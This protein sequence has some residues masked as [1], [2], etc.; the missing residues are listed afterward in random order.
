MILLIIRGHNLKE[1]ILGIKVCP[2]EFIGTQVTGEAGTSVEMVKNPEFSKWMSTDQLLMGWRYSSITPD[3]ATRVM[4]T[5]KS[6]E[7][8]T[9]IEESCAVQNRTRITFFIGELQK[10]RKGNLS[11]DQYLNKVKKKLTDNLE[12]VGKVIIHTDLITQVLAGLDE[13][14]TPIVVQ[15]NNREHIAWGELQSTLM[16]YESRPEHLSLIRNE[17]ARI[18]LDQTSANIS[19]RSIIRSDPV[20]KTWGEDSQTS[21]IIG[22]EEEVGAKEAIPLEVIGQFVFVK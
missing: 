12:I 6:N 8:W 17:M 14:Y 16:T 9:A 15:L 4:G 2:Q 1:Y 5:V 19:Q 21:A 11:I 13:H 20:G 18:S 10:S 22:V 3:I 7:L